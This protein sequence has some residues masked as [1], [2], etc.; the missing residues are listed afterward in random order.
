MNM[1]PSGHELI[2]DF[3]L[4]TTLQTSLHFLVVDDNALNKRL[5]ARTIDNM[6]F[7]S[8]RQRTP[9]YTLASDG[10]QSLPSSLAPLHMPFP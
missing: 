6:F 10:R 7:K 9:T 4:E 8:K 3:R 5:F 1:M 2:E